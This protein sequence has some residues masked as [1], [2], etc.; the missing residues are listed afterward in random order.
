MF[1]LDTLSENTKEY[2]GHSNCLTTYVFNPADTCTCTP[3]SENVSSKTAVIARNSQEDFKI[4]DFA[5]LHYSNKKNN[6]DNYLSQGFGSDSTGKKCCGR[7][8]YGSRRNLGPLYSIS[9]GLI[10]ERTYDEPCIGELPRRNWLCCPG[11]NEAQVEQPPLLEKKIQEPVINPPHFLLCT[12]VS[13]DKFLKINN[14]FLNK[15]FSLMLCI[16]IFFNF[17]VLPYLE[18]HC[19]V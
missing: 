17:I 10:E 3:S 2:G 6:L 9:Q 15:T 4:F 11:S 18:N 14:F 8:Y 5:S 1:I 12:C 19:A 16:H 13:Y 7:N